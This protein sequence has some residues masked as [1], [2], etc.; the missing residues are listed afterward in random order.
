MAAGCLQGSM[1]VTGKIIFLLEEPSM[2][3]FLDN[4]IPRAFPQIDFLCISHEGKQDLEKSIPRKLKAWGNPRPDFVILRDNDQANCRKVKEHLTEIC[5]RGG[6]SDTLIRIV[7][8][9]LESW[10]LG[11]P[12]SLAHAYS[13]PSLRKLLNGRK[14]SNP[15]KLASPSKELNRLLPQFRKYDGARRM[16]KSIPLTEGTNRSPSF[17]AFLAGMKRIAGKQRSHAR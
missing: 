2:K 10:Y 17:N 14:Y 16:G 9:E 13:K 7:C 1:E 6:R 15:D 3:E 4:F 8:Q 11:T 5:R 12:E